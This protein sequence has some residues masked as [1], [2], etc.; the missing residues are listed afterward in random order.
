MDLMANVMDGLKSLGNRN[1]TAA[2]TV[3]LDT[4][5]KD[6]RM[7]LKRIINRL[8]E[9]TLKSKSTIDL[10]VALTVVG[11]ASSIITAHTFTVVG[12]ALS[13]AR[14]IA[15]ASLITSL[16]DTHVKE[17]VRKRLANDFTDKSINAKT[18]FTFS[19]VDSIV[20]RSRLSLVVVLGKSVRNKVLR[21]SSLILTG[22]DTTLVG[23]RL[24]FS[25]LHETKEGQVLKAEIT[26]LARRGGG[27]SRG[28]VVRILED[29]GEIG[30]HTVTG[31]GFD[32]TMR[33]AR[34]DISAEL[35]IF[36]ASIRR[37][38]GRSRGSNINVLR[39]VL[40]VPHGAR[41]ASR[42][43]EDKSLEH[44]LGGHGAE[45]IS[46]IAVME[47]LISRH[48]NDTR[49]T[50]II[51]EN[52][53]VIILSGFKNLTTATS[54]RITRKNIDEVLNSSITSNIILYNTL[55]NI[56][57]GTTLDIE[58]V[59]DFTREGIHRVLSNII[60]EESDD[61]FIRNTGR[62]SKLISLAHG[63][64]VTIVG[65]ASGTSNKNNPGVTTFGL[66]SLNSLTEKFVLLV[67]KSNCN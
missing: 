24:S 14:S 34:S 22:S 60:L 35:R 42:H 4:S 45:N 53:N 1:A 46:K 3:E 64:L 23:M 44:L 63:R 12:S 30:I 40:V 54:S 7:V 39:E 59:V 61:T 36:K 18:D 57:V 15:V 6:V 65:P 17:F 16:A 50:V 28:I 9:G 48:S 66:A 55:I 43:E 33:P 10:L 11:L 32:P 25:V 37:S 58:F 41:I 19:L 2:E 62:V 26:I 52:E 20:L 27:L 38:R 8:A 56:D 13:N 67:C 51:V 29:G 47:E 49:V 21:N 31:K 5:R